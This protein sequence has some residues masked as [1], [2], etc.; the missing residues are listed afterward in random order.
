MAPQPRC[1]L[2]PREASHWVTLI[3][4]YTPHTPL[5]PF[6]LHTLGHKTQP[7]THTFMSVC[8]SSLANTISAH[9]HLTFTMEVICPGFSASS[10]QIYVLASVP[11]FVFPGFFSKRTRLVPPL[12]PPHVK[13]LTVAGSCWVIHLCHPAKM[14]TP[15]KVEE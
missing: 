4:S 1:S 8:A 6:P 9:T 12:H 7:Y 2:V 11:H 14:I 3:P 10:Y 5:C 13:V 15:I